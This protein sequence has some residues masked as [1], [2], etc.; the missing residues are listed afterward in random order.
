MDSPG[1][2][3]PI[4]GQ[5]FSSGTY[6]INFN[7][8]IILQD[9]EYTL[10]IE[11]DAGNQIVGNTEQKFKIE[12]E[13]PVISSAVLINNTDSGI[14]VDDRLTNILRPEITLNSEGG[15]RIFV[16]KS[17]NDDTFTLLSKQGIDSSPVYSV[18]EPNIDAGENS[19]YSITFLEDL[20]DGLYSIYFFK[21]VNMF[22][23]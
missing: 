3:E 11:D 20:T 12:T 17:N 1:F 2:R 10:I 5:S 14:S 8:G 19:Q 15:L 9:G 6:T 16:R 4:Y 23:I 18:V 22:I 21:K 13:K 7:D